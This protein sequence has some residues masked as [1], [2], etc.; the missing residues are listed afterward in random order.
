MI[1]DDIS[2][3]SENS[4]KNNMSKTNMSKTNMSKTNKFCKADSDINSESLSTE[5]KTY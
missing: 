1:H 2:I 5:N 4:S 3:L